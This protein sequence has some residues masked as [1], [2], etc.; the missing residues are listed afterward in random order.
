[1]AAAAE[2]DGAP[3]TAINV[4]PFVD[5]ILVV[6]VIFMA[7]APLISKRVLKVDVPK[8]AHHEKSATEALQITLDAK[9]EIHLA[10]Q[11]VG[12][13]DLKLRLSKMTQKDPDMRVTLSADK[14]IPYGE[15]VSFL[16]VLRGSGV[17]KLGLEVVRK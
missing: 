12:E 15:V 17:R 11:K 13:D 4:T 5:I 14:T 8:A 2:D 16:D 6:L 3:I 9:K 10:G 7:T 1:M